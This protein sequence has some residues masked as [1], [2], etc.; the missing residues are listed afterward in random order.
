M[1]KKV[2]DFRK[3]GLLIEKLFVLE[4]GQQPIEVLFR[5]RD[6]LTEETE[7]KLASDDR[8]LLQ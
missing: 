3:R 6:D 8:E 2:F 5:L 7:R 1:L 4:R